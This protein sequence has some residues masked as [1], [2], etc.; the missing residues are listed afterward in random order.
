M[1]R[2]LD[3]TKDRQQIDKQRRTHRTNLLNTGKQLNGRESRVFMF[4]WEVISR[5][6][7]H[8]SFLKIDRQ[9]EKSKRKHETC[10]LGRARHATNADSSGNIYQIN[11]KNGRRNIK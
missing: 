2:Q 7:R 11:G 10:S 1:D 8:K 4:L 9:G 3:I 5:K 6:N